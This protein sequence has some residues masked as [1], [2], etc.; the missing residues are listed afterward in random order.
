MGYSM[1]LQMP[2]GPRIG[3]TE[4]PKDMIHKFNVNCEF[5]SRPS[6]ADKYDNS[7]N[8]IGQI[9]SQSKFN[10]PM[11]NSKYVQWCVQQAEEFVTT[12]GFSPMKLKVQTAWYNRMMHPQEYNPQ[13]IHPVA[14]LTSVGYLKLPSNF[15]EAIQ[16][17]KVNGIGGGLELFYGENTNFS[18]TQS[19]II[20]SV[21]HYFIFPSTLRHAVYPMP[22]TITEERRSF[23]I[24]FEPA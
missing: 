17:N 15:T 6:Q 1:K 9:K 19:T 14:V 24:N 22:D 7:S 3:I 10:A 12:A 8:L 18:F 23:S 2:F 5:V 16:D 21:G 11:L 20:P 13:H 4:I